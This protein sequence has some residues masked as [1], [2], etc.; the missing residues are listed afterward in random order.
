MSQI[1]LALF[2]ILNA[3]YDAERIKKNKR[4][5]HAFNFIAYA[6]V[7]AAMILVLK[8]NKW[9]A[10]VY[11]VSAFLNRQIFF[12]IPLNLMRGLKWDYFSTEKPPKAIMDRIEIRI[13][14]YN[15]KL[16]VL[17]YAIGWIASIII[18]ELA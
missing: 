15:G 14:G 3:A 7:I 17:I 8:M 4:I 12:D 16:P 10:I 9:Q 5:Y 13:F 11:C 1:P 2:N 6:I 18:F